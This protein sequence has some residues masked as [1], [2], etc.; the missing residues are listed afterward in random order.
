[1]LIGLGSEISCDRP[2]CL[3]FLWF[4]ISKKTVMPSNLPG[5]VSA[6][7]RDRSSTFYLR[8]R[9]CGSE[10]VPYSRFKRPYS[11]V[12]F[13]MEVKWTDTLSVLSRSPEIYGGL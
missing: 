12:D 10:K 9:D 2:A 11:S 8:G 7:V 3:V 1:M 4:W 13:L 6:E 5:S